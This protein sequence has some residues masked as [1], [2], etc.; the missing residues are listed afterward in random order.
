[1]SELF[2][3][4]KESDAEELAPF[5]ASLWHS[6]YD[7]LLGPAQVDYMTGKF[8]SAAEIRRQMREDGYLYYF[9]RRGGENIGYCALHPEADSLFLSKL[10][11]A[12]NCRGKGI[13]QRALGEVTGIARKLGKERVYLTV[14]K[15]NARAVRAY[16]KFGFTLAESIV[17]DIGGGFAMDDF[18]YE[19][20]L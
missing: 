11:L 15:G 3:Q 8:Q 5:I 17:T 7:G 10:Y 19:Y 13:G 6:A 4:A 1:M 18:V 14:N 12:E 20:F 16:E 2:V 9:L